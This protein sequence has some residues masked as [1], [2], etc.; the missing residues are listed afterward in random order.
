MTSYPHIWK[1]TERSHFLASVSNQIHF[2]GLTQPSASFSHYEDLEVSDGEKG[3]SA[4]G[5]EQLSI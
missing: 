3:A 2:E 1:N 5:G 4:G